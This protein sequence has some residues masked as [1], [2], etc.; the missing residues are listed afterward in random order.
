MF[1]MVVPYEYITAIT[2]DMLANLVTSS[3][4]KQLP[5]AMHVPLGLLEF[6]V[7]S[8]VLASRFGMCGAMDALQHTAPCPFTKTDGYVSK[9]L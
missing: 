7:V 9:C 1:G 2:V 5:F 6:F 3:L 4:I 8:Y